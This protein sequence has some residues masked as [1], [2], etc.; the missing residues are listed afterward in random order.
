VTLERRPEPVEGSRSGTIDLRGNLVE[1]ALPRLD[2]FLDDASL[3]GLDQVRLLHGVG[4]GR[5]R[6]AVRDYIARHPQV[7]AFENAA[8][9]QGGEG[10]TIVSLR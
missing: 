6:R 3:Q 1:D 10:A 2:K 5:L 7:R 4:S 9:D 8:E